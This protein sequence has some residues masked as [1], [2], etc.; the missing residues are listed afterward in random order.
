MGIAQMRIHDGADGIRIAKDVLALLVMQCAGTK[1]M[2]ARQ[3]EVASQAL[4]QR[5]V[6]NPGEGRLLLSDFHVLHDGGFEAASCL[7]HL[8]G[9]LHPL[10]EGV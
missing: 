7:V 10:P 8:V 9:V 4:G 2:L 1:C 6:L 5:K 3:V